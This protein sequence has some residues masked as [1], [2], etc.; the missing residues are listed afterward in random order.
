MYNTFLVFN[1]NK[2]IF[3]KIFLNL[4]RRKY[5][6]VKMSKDTDFVEQGVLSATEHLL[7]VMW[8]KKSSSCAFTNQQQK[9]QQQAAFII[10]AVINGLLSATEKAL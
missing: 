9:Q 8:I 6:L 5:N 10:V 3:F 7:F 4:Y 1:P 2:Y